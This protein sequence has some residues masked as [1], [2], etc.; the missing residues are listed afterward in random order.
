MTNVTA[1]TITAGEIRELLAWLERAALDAS[2]AQ[3]DPDPTPPRAP[4][5]RVEIMK[6]R[7]RCAAILAA[8]KD[9]HAD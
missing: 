2:F 5:L 8:R 7:A 4:A 6:A 9:P 3:M 1:E